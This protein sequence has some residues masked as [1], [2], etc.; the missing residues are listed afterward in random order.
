MSTRRRRSFLLSLVAAAVWASVLPTS[1]AAADDLLPD[2][3][4]K[5]L[6]DMY[7][8]RTSAGKVRLRF[9]TVIVNVGEGPFE[10]RG[11]RAEGDDCGSGT[12][13][14]ETVQ[15]LRATD[16]TARPVPSDAI[17][18]YGGDGHP[19]W[20]IRDIELYELRSLHDPSFRVRFGFKRGYC[21]FDNVGHRLSLPGAPSSP[22]YHESG[23]GW[24]SS[25]TAFMGL[26]VG[27]GDIYPA[28]FVQQWITVTN[29]PR[30][31]YRVC[32]TADPY[33]DYVETIETNNM[34]WSDI[35][36]DAAAGTV[37]VL[38]RGH[39][40]CYAEPPA[41]RPVSRTALLDRLL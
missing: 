2:L 31:R 21:F 36:L 17:M 32:V 33:A 25:T 15:R 29:V 10:V 6:T 24:P 1:V 3:R 41:I 34:T 18:C 9:A 20:H 13:F 35:R 38:A 7:V 28:N 19:H 39:G 26:S 37:E 23:C 30:G 16:G 40:R 4:M 27:W 14:M 22:R 5:K 12:A 11:T 8:E